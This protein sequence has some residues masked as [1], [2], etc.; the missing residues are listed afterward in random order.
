MGVNTALG[1]DDIGGLSKSDCQTFVSI[2]NEI[3]LL[4]SKKG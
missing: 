3:G 4:S 1:S 2:N